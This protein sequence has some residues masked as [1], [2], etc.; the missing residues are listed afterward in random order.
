MPIKEL[1]ERRN[2]ILTA[3]DK[4]VFSIKESLCLFISPLKHTLWVLSETV[5]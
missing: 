1:G 2:K 4:A 5:C 3:L